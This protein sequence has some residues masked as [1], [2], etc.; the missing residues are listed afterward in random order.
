MSNQQTAIVPTADVAEVAQ[1]ALENIIFELPAVALCDEIE[2]HFSTGTLS[3]KA[4]RDVYLAV[5]ALP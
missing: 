5:D 2:H 4:P 3:F 1:T